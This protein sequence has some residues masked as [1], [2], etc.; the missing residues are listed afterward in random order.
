MKSVGLIAVNT[1]SSNQHGG[2][3]NDDG[4]S[5]DNDDE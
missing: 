1:L 2:H 4:D 3:G 5:D